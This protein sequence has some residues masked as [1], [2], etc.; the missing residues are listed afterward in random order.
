MIQVTIDTIINVTNEKEK[1]KVA[2][3]QQKMLK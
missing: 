3:V 2:L 1:Y